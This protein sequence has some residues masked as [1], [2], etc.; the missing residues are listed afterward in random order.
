M[1]SLV[2]GRRKNKYRAKRTA[3][4]FP[5]KL[6]AAVWALLLAR[7]KAGEIK[8]IQR[9]ATVV[10]QDG[11]REVKI[12]WRLDFSFER[13]STGATE[14]VEAKGMETETY[15]LKL[16]LWRKNPPAALEIWKG[17]YRRPALAERIEPTHQEGR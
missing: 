6:E 7:E 5:S 15:R 10:L 8:N 4:G 3:D 1:R 12:T 17:D 9:Q 11:P 2:F 13:K 16:K 14:Y